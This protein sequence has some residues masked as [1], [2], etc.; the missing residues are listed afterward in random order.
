MAS[1]IESIN[2]VEVY[3][4]NGVPLNTIRSKKPSIQIRE[5][6]SWSD[7][8]IVNMG[9]VSYTVVASDLEKAIQNAK[10]AH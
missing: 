10:N 1:R 5:H 6:G 9:G 7:F 2:N 4:E 3:E 8:V